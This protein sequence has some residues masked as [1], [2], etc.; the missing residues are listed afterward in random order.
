MLCSC[1]LQCRRIFVDKKSLKYD[2]QRFKTNL[3]GEKY[4]RP[5]SSN[6]NKNYNKFNNREQ[7]GNQASKSYDNHQNKGIVKYNN[8]RNDTRQC[9][10]CG[11]VG[12][13]KRFCT[14]KVYAI[15]YKGKKQDEANVITVMRSPQKSKTIGYIKIIGRALSS[16]SFLQQ[17]SDL[18]FFHKL[19]FEFI[20]I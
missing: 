3:K 5:Y 17:P 4:K 11:K 8:Q 18:T 9:H 16:I 12:D 13:I 15:E 1:A 6:Y 20:A 2:N 7:S 19:I 10:K 14:R